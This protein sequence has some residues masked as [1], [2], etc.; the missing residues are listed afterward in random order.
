MSFF[1][2]A[3]WPP[4]ANVNDD[5][6]VD[7]F[8]QSCVYDLDK[9]NKIKFKQFST[10]FNEID[11]HMLE[12][13]PDYNFFFHNNLILDDCK[14][15]FSDDFDII[16]NNLSESSMS[17][18]NLN[19]NSIPKNFD[20]FLNQLLPSINHKF[21]ILS[22]CETKLDN[23]IE[24]LYNID[25]YA[26]FNLNHRR[27]SGGLAMFINLN[28]SNVFQRHDLCV[29]ENEIETLFVEIPVKD[30]KNILCGV[31]YHRPGTNK[32]TFLDKLDNI[33]TTCVNERKLLYI[34][35]DF[36]LDLVS[37]NLNNYSKELINLFHRKNIY[38]LI[39]KPTRV[40][41]ST[42]TLIDHIWSNDYNNSLANGII[43]DNSISDHFPIFSIFKISNKFCNSKDQKSHTISFR[44]FSS[45]NILKF[46]NELQQVDWNL[47]LSSN[48]ANVAS[49]N[50]SLIF[51]N[52]F[53]KTFPLIVKK[54]KNSYPQKPYITDEIKSLIKQKNKLQRKFAKW[55]ITYNEQYKQA[56][57]NVT[58][59]LKTAKNNYFKNK[60]SSCSGDS[61]GTWKVL[62]SILQNKSKKEATD[63]FKIELDDSTVLHDNQL[64]SNA[65]NNHFVNVGKILSDKIVS[66]NIDPI[67]F[68]GNPLINSIF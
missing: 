31:V 35:G 3:N 1:T 37:D 21:D 16:N 30:N 56:R 15:Y 48:D 41:N 59:I 11:R 34:S 7:L 4:F 68:M 40:T 18:L 38:S 43:Y 54:L 67:T 36:N 50:F 10:D 53:N 62:N 60:L 55:P 61:R 22:F 39:D 42:A 5:D 51:N 58:Q 23:K 33:V 66:Q 29:S 47:I 25:G 19:I 64:I 49:N 45:D 13:D 32:K 12:M 26:R 9:L 8:H 14:Y 20:V 6:F 52:I 65:F 57:N 44:K 46:K 24:H 17:L 63:N 27:N 2:E 28:Y